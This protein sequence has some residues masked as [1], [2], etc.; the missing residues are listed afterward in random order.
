MSWHTGEMVGFDLETTGTNPETDRIVTAAVVRVHVSRGTVRRVT[1]LADP[2]VDIPAEATAVHGVSTEHARQYG[3]PVA[4]V[5]REL[6]GKLR[7]A[8]R[9]NVPVVAFNA[10]FDLTLLDRELRRHTGHGLGTPGPVVDPLVI[11]RAVDRYR[12]GSRKLTAACVHYRIPLSA[13]QAH[14]SAGDALAATR[15]AW[16]LAEQFPPITVGL[17]ELQ[18]RQAD[19]HRQ[20]AADFET[21]LREKKTRDGATPGEI[22]AVAIDRTWPLRPH[23]PEAAA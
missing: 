12:P 13:E 1:W 7:A 16:R 23:I 2:G 18:T 11:D 14:T 22:A 21:W 10:A 17:D 5:V 9:R 15:L 19:W 6:A 4:Q 3:E 8:W 20:W